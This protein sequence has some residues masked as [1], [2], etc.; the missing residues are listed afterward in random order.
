[1]NF[2][3]SAN[4]GDCLW[5]CQFLR[6]LGGEH[7]FY[8]KDAY[9]EQLAPLMADTAHEIRPISTWP[10]DG[11]DCWIANGRYEHKGCYYQTK[12]TSWAL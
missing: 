4:I 11:I 6:R 7:H 12:P 5:A 2:S 9:V 10:G 1:M 8:V 3:T